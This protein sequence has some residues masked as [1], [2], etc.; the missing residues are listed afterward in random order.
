MPGLTIY[1]HLPEVG[2][3]STTTVE[4]T[5]A[6]LGIGWRVLVLT[7]DLVGHGYS[8]AAQAELERIG[9]TVLRIDNEAGK[10]QPANFLAALQLA[11]REYRDAFLAIGTRYISGLFAALHGAHR[12]IYYSIT[13]H[14]GPNSLVSRL[15]PFFHHIAVITPESLDQSRKAIWI[16]Q[17]A[18]V[19]SATNELAAFPAGSPRRF[20]FLG[21]FTEHKGINI[22][23]NFWN[24]SRPLAELHVCGQ[25]PLL[26]AVTNSPAVIRHPSFSAADR[27]KALAAFFGKIDTL[28]VPTQ[29]DGEGLPNVILEALDHG[30]P[31]VTTP[32][33]G[34]RLFLNRSEFTD[35]SVIRFVAPSDWP[36]FLAAEI[37]SPS[38]T[39]EQRQAARDFVR[40]HFSTASVT[41]RWLAIL[42]GHS[43]SQR[44]S[45]D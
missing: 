41:C 14:P 15:A 32:L 42:D 34:T 40:L 33:G 20:G 29:T 22:L 44:H 37:E 2:G 1:S 36:A 7:R 16:P 45:I 39:I 35:Q 13:H 21:R 17:L 27:S 31:V 3:H 28:L 19:G 11:R 24:T 5:R 18:G 9:A 43:T 30:V 8:P 12:R 10:L 6:F 38:P 25:G 23:L 26:E 4:L